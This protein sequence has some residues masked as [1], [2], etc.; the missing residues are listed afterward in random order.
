MDAAQQLFREA[1]VIQKR[2]LTPADRRNLGK[3]T[4]LADAAKDTLSAAIDELSKV[5]GESKPDL[6]LVGRAEME[7]TTEALVDKLQGTLELL[8]GGE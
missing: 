3:L 4:A 5:T 7:G 6:R 8:G 1:A 2:S